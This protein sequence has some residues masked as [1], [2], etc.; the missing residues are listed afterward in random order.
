MTVITI[1]FETSDPYIKRGVGS[2]WVYGAN[3]PSSDFIVLGAGIKVNGEE[4][5]YYTD[6]LDI[7]DEVLEYKNDTFV[8][9]NAQY[10]LGCLIYLFKKHNLDLNILRNINII[11]TSIL[12]RLYY[13]VLP[14]HSL[15]FLAKKFLN[16][17]KDNQGLIDSVV[18]NDLYPWTKKDL[19]AKMKDPSFQR[20]LDPKKL[21]KFSKENMEL[22]AQIDPDCVA[23]YCLQ[24][25]DCTYSLY[26]FLMPKVEEDLAHKYSDIQ[27]VCCF[28]RLP[29]IR[30][31]YYQVKKVQ[32]YMEN[33][34]QKTIETLYEL[35]GVDF[36]INSPKQ[37]AEVL[38]LHHIEYPMTPK[39][40]PSVT[41]PW[42]KNQDSD[43]CSAIV[44]ARKYQKI[45][46]DFIDKIL[47]IKQ[48]TAP[49]AE[50]YG[51]I[52]P[53]LQPLRA[54]T[55]RFSCSGPNIQQIPSRDEE[56]GPLCRSIFV[57]EEGEKWYSLDYSNQEGRL[58]VHYASLLRC[59]QSEE[60][61]KA[62]IEDPNLDMHQK[63]ADMVGI[64]RAEAKT[65][66]LGVSYGM[67][68]KKL[69]KSL[70][71][72]KEEAKHVLTKYNNLAPYL[73]DLNTRCM[74]VLKERG[75]IKTLGGRLS[76]IDKPIWD[77]ELNKRITFEYK[78]LN[79]LIQGSAADQ[80][81][82]A[83]LCAFNQGLTV[84]TAIH[85]QICLSGSEEDAI[86]MKEIMET[87][88]QLSVPMVV[89]VDL[90]GGINWKESG[91]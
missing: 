88:V 86:K 56:L 14:S 6:T 53:E 19:A 90:N 50:R 69:A 83:L 5:V 81:I 43:L 39:G 47:E 32:D 20:T 30:V 77:K 84:I 64:S 65:I 75:H 79:K 46:N 12:S 24:D 74:T 7:V 42:M 8:M 66:N 40:N 13:N 80:I 67:G 41:T 72:S 68:I 54:V 34:V 10:D 70:N 48:Y 38:D 51:R 1:D 61:R 16:M 87:C 36:N 22:L 33:K 35:A 49:D 31:D 4:S 57:P 82:E 21:E 11:D 45:K 71:I 25:V 44:E 27:K 78:A 76:K 23:K 55:G 28:N 9:H 73:H 91:H 29:G 60:L 52:Y 18:V 89:D 62:F 15:D 59:R 17:K 3:I 63:V 2:G 58:Q 85:D 37:V 26:Q